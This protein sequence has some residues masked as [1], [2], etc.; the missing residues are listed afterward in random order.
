[1]T[2]TPSNDNAGAA[3]RT[4]A[5]DRE[6]ASLATSLAADK[7]ARPAAAAPAA[8]PPRG[9]QRAVFSSSV[10]LLFSF[11][12]IMVAGMLWWQYRQFYVS[13]D[14]TDAAAADALARVRA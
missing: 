12:A 9:V 5:A 6:W 14:Q 3:P 7:A 4:P 13:L 11:I 1:M 2:D 10:A 8:E